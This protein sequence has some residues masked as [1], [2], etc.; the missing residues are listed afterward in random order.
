MDRSVSIIGA[1]RV[2]TAIAVSLRDGGLTIENVVSRK[3]EDAEWLA[4]RV[5][6][7]GFDTTLPTAV[8]KSDVLFITTPD[9]EIARVAR[10]LTPHL[11]KRSLVAHVS[12][13]YP[14]EILRPVEEQGASILAMHP[15][16]AFADKATAPEQLPGSYF[17]LEGKK[18]AIAR[19][20]TLAETM[21]CPS[22][23]LPAS[24]KALY[25]VACT[26]ASNYL[27][28]LAERASSVLEE[29]GIEPEEALRILLPLV[30]GTLKNIERLGAAPSLTGP[31][32]RGDATTVAEQVATVNDRISDLKILFTTLGREA[33]QL[34]VKK[35]SLTP[36]EGDRLSSSLT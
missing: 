36:D 26:V 32:E 25:H 22:F 20:R 33:V 9:R 1:G 30:R 23:V 28:V 13:T 7:S 34:A 24:E 18:D 29:T 27:V 11:E 3:K 17:C 21:R 5:G 12:G 4:R 19:G 2:G 15:C 10:D 31:I 16:Q 14:S 35:G 6:A 8:G